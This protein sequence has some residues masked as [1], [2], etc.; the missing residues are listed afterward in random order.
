MGRPA[1]AA[2]GGAVDA[3][4]SVSRLLPSAPS[5]AEGCTCCPSVDKDTPRVSAPGHWGRRRANSGSRLGELNVPSV[6][7]VFLYRT[8]LLCHVRC[9]EQVIT[10]TIISMAR[11]GHVHGPSKECW[12]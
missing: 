4:D 10:V 5:G 6:P 3:G 8:V 12:A 11:L 1:Q 7:R 9:H 2:C